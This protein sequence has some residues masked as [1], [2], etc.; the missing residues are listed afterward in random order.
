V[1]KNTKDACATEA[2][3]IATYTAIEQVAEAAG[4]RQTARLAASIRAQEEA[5]LK[6]LLDELPG[7]AQSVV[8]GSYDV[9]RTPGG[10]AARAAGRA[11]RA[12]VRA[13]QGT[14]ARNARKVPGVAHAEGELKGLAASEGDL[15]LARYG[16]LTAAEIAS[17]LRDLSQLD[18]SKIDAYERKNQGR[19][20][21]LERIA[22]LRADE[23]WA[24]YDELTVGEIKTALEGAD[25][26]LAR[27]I[28]TYERAH[29]ARTGV[30]QAVDSELSNA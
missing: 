25:E 17:R 29:K 30:L 12:A 1:L 22:A 10:A 24:G 15:A 20:T 16:S 5:M 13:V 8:D 27:T 2:L 7:L 21:V 6:R 23:P 4:D 11:G 9:T 18:L 26:D 14:T 28:R 19:S 3:E